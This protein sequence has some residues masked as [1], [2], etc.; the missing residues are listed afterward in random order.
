MLASMTGSE[1]FGILGVVHVLL[2]LL[3]SGRMRRTVSGV[4]GSRQNG[5]TTASR[6]R[7]AFSA[8]LLQQLEHRMCPRRCTHETKF[9]LLS[10]FFF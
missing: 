5:Q 6:D 4:N 10:K 7:G 8:M 9:S 3:K 1:N 2:L